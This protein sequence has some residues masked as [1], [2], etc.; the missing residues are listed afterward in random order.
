MGELLDGSDIC[1]LR[2]KGVETDVMCKGPE[3]T[4][5]TFDFLYYW[6]LL[7]F[8]AFVFWFLEGR[9]TLSFIA[10]P[11]AFVPFYHIL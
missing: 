11:V 1:I 4:K 7:S 3:T 9:K 10:L 5:G 8:E 6:N 2:R